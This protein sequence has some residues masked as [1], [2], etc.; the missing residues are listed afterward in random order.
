M[1]HRTPVRLSAIGIAALLLCAGSPPPASQLDAQEGI[2]Q[3]V[4][5]ATGTDRAVFAPLDR[6]AILPRFLGDWAARSGKCI[7][8]SYKDRMG[9]T[10]DMAIVAGHALIV[11][12]VYVDAGAPRDRAGDE[13]LLS[14]DFADAQEMLVSFTRAGEEETRFIHFEFSRKSGRLIVEEVGQPRRAYV[15]CSMR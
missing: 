12:A 4:E 15:R 2:G 1:A 10:P 6:P 11:G 3:I 7:G 14:P 9:L 5:P 8:Q 13:P